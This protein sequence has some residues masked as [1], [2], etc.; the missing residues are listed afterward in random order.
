MDEKQFAS[1]RQ[2]V[3][4]VALE[5]ILRF[6]T[7]QILRLLKAVPVE[8]RHQ[9]LSVFSHELLLARR[10]I[11]DIAFENRPPELSDL[12][13]GELQEALDDI[14]KEIETSLNTL[15]RIEGGAS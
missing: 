15:L 1:L 5:A 3:R 10:E 2:T 12:L 4:L 7:S 11:E 13:A 9:A 8:P 6:Q 14:C